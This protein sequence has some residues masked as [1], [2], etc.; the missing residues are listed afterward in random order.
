[1]LIILRF[2]M[3]C[4]KMSDPLHLECKD[5]DH[6]TPLLTATA[7]GSVRAMD[8][9]VPKVLVPKDDQIDFDENDD[10][11]DEK[12]DA[13]VSATDN[14]DSNIFHIAVETGDVNVL[15]VRWITFVIGVDKLAYTMYS[16]AT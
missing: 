4:R 16:T 8:V 13:L 1:M 6:K 7:F 5:K 12:Y 2:F 9:F 3:S 15:K 11:D 10:D 14:R